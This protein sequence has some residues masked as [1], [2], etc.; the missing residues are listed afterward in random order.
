[1]ITKQAYA[2]VNTYLDVISK[3]DDGFHDILSVMRAVSLADTVRVEV[4]DNSVT[5][6]NLSVSGADLP[7]DE[8]NL[9][10]RAAAKLLEKFGFCSEINIEIEI[11]MEAGLAGGSTDAAATIS[12]L[13]EHYG[14]SDKAALLELALEI[15]SDVPFCLVGG[16]ML[17]GGRGEK[18]TP[19]SGKF[20]HLVIAIGNSRVNT[21]AAYRRL[22]ELHDDFKSPKKIL[23]EDYESRLYNIFEET[24]DGETLALKERLSAL[25]DGGALMS[26][27]G[28]SIFGIFDTEEAA[29]AARDSLIREGYTAYYAHTL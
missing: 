12:A 6:I 18:M 15:G 5:S 4:L 11:P 8:R 28:P 16:S 29:L 26:G 20:M 13:A 19:V 2:K 3:R 14:I 21:A 7:C 10:Y 22:D 17:C 24:A 23:P 25:S 27:S 9:A 1:M